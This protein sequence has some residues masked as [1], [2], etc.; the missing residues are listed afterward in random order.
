MTIQRAAPH[1][2]RHDVGDDDQSHLIDPEQK[3]MV[4]ISRQ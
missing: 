4:T 3:A 1:L 2:R